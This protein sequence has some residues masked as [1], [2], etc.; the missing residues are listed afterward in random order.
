MILCTLL[1]CI[2]DGSDEHMSALGGVIFAP[3]RDASFGLIGSWQAQNSGTG[4][5]K[6]SCKVG[7]IGK[8]HFCTPLNIFSFPP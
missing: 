2:S 6:K 8:L 5:P 3:G 4:H 7:G 1:L